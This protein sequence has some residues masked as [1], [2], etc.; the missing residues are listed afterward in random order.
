MAIVVVATAACSR[1]EQHLA[2]I[3]A[4]APAPAP[5]DAGA[6]PAAPDAGVDA[7]VDA[8]GAAPAHKHGASHAAGGEGGGGAAGLQVSGRLDKAEVSKVLRAKA[9]SMRACYQRERSKN[10]GLRGRVTFRVTIDKRGL[11]KIAEAEKSTLG[12]GDAEMCMVQTVRD[13][14]FPP[15][16]SGGESTVSFQMGFGGK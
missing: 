15:D 4:A 8:A 7:G 13:M 14:R 3:D 11:V 2:P 5:R 6:P 1:S 12:G 10:P 9:G 16:P